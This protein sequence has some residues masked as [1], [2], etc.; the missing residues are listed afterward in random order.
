MTIPRVLIIY[1]SFSG[2]TRKLL[3][4]FA[5]GLE[6]EGV[7]V[8]WQQLEP[9]EKLR[10]PFGSIAL[11][12]QMMIVT[13]FRKR[14]VI[15]PLRS[16]SYDSWDV[17]ILA[18][19]TWSYNPSGVVLDCL[20]R[21]GEIFTRRKVLPFIS[22]R[23]YWRL[24]YYQLRYLLRK[25]K[26]EILKPIVFLHPEPE[27]WRTIGVFLKMAGRSPESPKTWFGNYYKR[28][29]HSREQTNLAVQAGSR[30]AEK[31]K[32]NQGF[33]DSATVIGGDVREE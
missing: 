6:N 25:K 18:G 16:K 3:L 23:S 26:A 1:F 11:T 28:F 15:E 22:C 24:H 19:P 9:L 7:E 12:L 2:Q 29:G 21:Y 14:F 33:N 27:P 4:A 20:D 31:I 13:F 8:E 32:E 17:I 5:A 10:F 30:F